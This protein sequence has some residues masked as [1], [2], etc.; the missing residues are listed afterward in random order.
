MSASALLARETVA[1]GE[2][3]KYPETYYFR[4]ATLKGTAQQVKPLG[5]YWSKWCVVSGSYTFVL[6]DGTGAIDV[7]VGG[8]CLG[9]GN[10]TIVN[11]GDDVIVEAV[12]NKFIGGQGPPTIKASARDVRR[13]AK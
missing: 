2:I 5:M 9:L 10:M 12:I 3:L 7:E 13:V 8:T 6:D 4:I 1:I 11:N